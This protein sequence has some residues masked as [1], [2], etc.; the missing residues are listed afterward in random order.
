MRVCV[1]FDFIQRRWRIDFAS[2]PSGT[3]RYLCL[4][5]IRNE[6][7]KCV[8][9]RCWPPF[10][11]D[12]LMPPL[13]D[14]PEKPTHTHTHAA[15]HLTVAPKRPAQTACRL[16]SINKPAHNIVAADAIVPAPNPRPSPDVT[17]RHARALI[18]IVSAPC[19]VYANT[20]VCFCM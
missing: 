20:T 11:T 7:S 9:Q 18:H 15:S 10:V 8:R 13:T 19:F 16:I 17:R 4:K 2:R 1:I 6:H 5:N 3:S 12:G 14:T